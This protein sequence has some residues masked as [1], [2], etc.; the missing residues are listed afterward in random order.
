MKRIP[1]HGLIVGL[2]GF[3]GLLLTID[4]QLIWSEWGLEGE[5]AQWGA[6]RSLSRWNFEICDIKCNLN[7]QLNKVYTLKLLQFYIKTIQK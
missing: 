3:I 1:V 2:D 7:V 5:A 6:L 4:K